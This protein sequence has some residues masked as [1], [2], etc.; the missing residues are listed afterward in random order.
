MFDELIQ[1]PNR[2]LC[3][4]EI[5]QEIFCNFKKKRKNNIKN[6]IL[7]KAQLDSDFILSC[8]SRSELNPLMSVYIKAIFDYRLNTT[9]LLA[10]FEGDTAKISE[11]DEDRIEPCRDLYF[12]TT[13]IGDE[14]AYN[15]LLYQQHNRKDPLKKAIYNVYKAKRNTEHLIGIGKETEILILNKN[16]LRSIK[17]LEPLENIYIKELNCGKERAAKIKLEFEDMESTDV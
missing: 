10:G 1:L 6:E 8:L 2:D 4:S 15:T 9:I 5:S 12:T 3:Y 16:G 14:A 17:D 11:I 7:D 13:G